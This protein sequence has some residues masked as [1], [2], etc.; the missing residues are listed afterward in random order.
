MEVECGGVGVRFEVLRG[1]SRWA[2]ATRLPIVSKMAMAHGI[3]KRV[4]H[5]VG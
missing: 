3:V 2:H 1:P 4:Q 5:D